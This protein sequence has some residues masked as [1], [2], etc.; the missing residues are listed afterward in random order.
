MNKSASSYWGQFGKFMG[1]VFAIL[2]FFSVINSMFLPGEFWKW[3]LGV[4][5]LIVIVAVGLFRT[6]RTKAQI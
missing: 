3:V 2:L 4:M 6:W 1:L 5:C